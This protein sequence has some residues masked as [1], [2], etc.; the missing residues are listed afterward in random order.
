MNKS[1]LIIVLA[2]LQGAC[3]TTGP[4]ADG[5]HDLLTFEQIAGEISVH[6]EVLNSDTDLSR[7]TARN[8]L[9]GM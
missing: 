7:T 4:E 5:G 6:H 3:A 8:D 9:S 1:L 2:L